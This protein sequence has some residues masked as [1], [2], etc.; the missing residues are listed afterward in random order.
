MILF[1]LV[2]CH[3][4]EVREETVEKVKDPLL[5][6]YAQTYEPILRNFE[7]IYPDIEL[8]LKSLKGQID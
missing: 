8:E 3:N 4:N 7:R 1:A 2:G 6:F 5:V